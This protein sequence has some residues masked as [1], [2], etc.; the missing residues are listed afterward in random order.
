MSNKRWK[1]RI[2]RIRVFLP[3]AFG[4]FSIFILVSCQA[5][6]VADIA[7][8]PTPF[9]VEQILDTQHIAASENALCPGEEVYRNLPPDYWQE[10]WEN[11]VLH[12]PT[13]S[14]AGIGLTQLSA[15]ISIG[16][17]TFE[18]PEN[19]P[20]TATIRYYYP[21]SEQNSIPILIRYFLLVDE[22]QVQTTINGQLG[23]TFDLLLVPGD[24]GAL[25][26]DI[27]PLSPGIHDLYFL[28][29]TEVDKDPDVYGEVRDLSYRFTLVAGSEPMI[30]T[31]P[32]QHLK[33]EKR[34][35]FRL[36]NSGGYALIVSTHEDEPLS[37]WNWPETSLPVQMG[38]TLDFYIYAGY[39]HAENSDYWY[40]K[41][42]RQN[43]FA[44]VLLMDYRQV[45]F[46]SESP[47]FYG[48]A[49]RNNDY[50][51]LPV[52]LFPPQSPGRH[53]MVVA[54]INYPGFPMCLMVMD[55]DNPRPYP[56]FVDLKR[57][58]IDVGH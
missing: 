56:S 50:S 39:N 31:R 29:L 49:D 38:A 24:E 44:L 12:P 42:P 54:R 55:I 43:P 37:I 6:Q 21:A 34:V 16:D 13:T 1:P 14:G 52:H 45:S 40:A 58:A 17:Y 22:Q 48:I 4:L 30:L 25:T 2:L 9:D 57:F 18:V 33:A 36:G 35:L 3:F 41:K 46:S 7:S 15:G 8:Y 47:V 32:Y 10:R 27:P 20:L 26:I 51:R 28:G 19:A 11:L 23:Y 53:E 5:V